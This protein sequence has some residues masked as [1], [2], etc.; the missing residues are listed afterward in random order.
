MV[1]M[2]SFNKNIILFVV[3]SLLILFGYA[4]NIFDLYSAKQTIID[5]INSDLSVQNKT[6]SA[7]KNLLFYHD[8]MIDINSLKDNISNRRIVEKDDGAV[9]KT[10][11]NTLSYYS[12]LDTIEQASN[13]V[14]NIIELKKYADEQGAGFLCVAIPKKAQYE[15]FPPN[16]N[17]Y[18]E[19]NYQ[20][21]L[22][23]LNGNDVPM[24]DCKEA[25]RQESI[26]EDEVFFRTD[27]HWKPY[28]G[29][30]VAKSVCESLKKEYSFEYNKVYTDIENYDRTEYKD[31]FLGSLGKK[32]GYYFTWNGADDFEIIT[33]KFETSFSEK[34]FDTDTI[35]SGSFTD[36]L[37]HK[38]FLNKDY[39][40]KN[41]YAAYSG[42]DFRLQIIKNNNNKTGPKIVV[43]RNS[44]A[45][46]V[47]PFLALQASELDIIDD[48]D[49]N[50]PSG[51]KINIKEFIKETKPD[52]VITI[53]W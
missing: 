22:V 10:N 8:Y 36:T 34:T 30:V 18:S 41:P 40:H 37:L 6:E 33:P 53:K 25:L 20:N 52:Y 35:R 3:A 38:N 45:G 5:A 7:L 15:H 16:V 47:T 13:R 4:G 2:K 42:G 49:G 9:V 14:N 21:Y 46:V 48:R 23:A 24:L 32:V 28:I 17:D 1:I 51:E 50:Y 29:F 27:H 11:N 44:F 26:S 31:F 12:D 43:V 39:Y 19:E